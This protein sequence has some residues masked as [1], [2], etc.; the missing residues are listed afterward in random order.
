MQAHLGDDSRGRQ[1]QLPFERRSICRLPLS[2]EFAAVDELLERNETNVDGV[3]RQNP[4]AGGAKTNRTRNPNRPSEPEWKQKLRL[5]T[6][7]V[8]GNT[9]LDQDSW[10]SGREIIYLI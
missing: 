2:L 3:V 5:L 6:A 8:H 1:K 4:S 10:P 9:Q 7:F